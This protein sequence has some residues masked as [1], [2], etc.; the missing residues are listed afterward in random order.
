MEGKPA[1]PLQ[2]VE[3]IPVAASQGEGLIKSEALLERLGLA[4]MVATRQLNFFMATTRPYSTTTWISPST[5]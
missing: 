2:V 4:S 3:K 5:G 1:A